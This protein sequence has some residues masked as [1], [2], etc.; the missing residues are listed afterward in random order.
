MRG[1]YL[2]GERVIMG[3]IDISDRGVII[4][5]G[6]PER[7][8]MVSLRA[9]ENQSGLTVIFLSPVNIG[10]RLS[11]KI[12]QTPSNT[13]ATVDILLQSPNPNSSGYWLYFILGITPDIM[14][15][16]F[17]SEPR[18]RSEQ[19]QKEWEKLENLYTTE[20]YMSPKMWRRFKYLCSLN[21]Y[22]AP[23]VPTQKAR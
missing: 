20:R 22:I 2:K 23:F 21:R 19:E 6:Y 13:E 18:R 4:S 9:L 11:V 1:N 12:M 10:E 17:H 3:K 16:I 8:V 14:R 7:L 15:K 5:G